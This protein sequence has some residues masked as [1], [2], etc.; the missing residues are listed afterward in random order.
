VKTDDT[1]PADVIEA[2]EPLL[3]AL[4]AWDPDDEDLAN[5]R[6]VMQDKL[7]RFRS[8]MRSS[9]FV[10]GRRYAVDLPGQHSELV[11]TRMHDGDVHA[12]L[13]DAGEETGNVIRFSV[14]DPYNV[15]EVDA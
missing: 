5:R 9:R 7:H 3:A 12:R 11:V 1:D 8:E 4:D 2:I 14:E 10:V 6:M 15:E 13:V